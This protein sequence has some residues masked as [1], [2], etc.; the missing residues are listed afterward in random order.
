MHITILG[1]SPSWQDAG[2]ACTGYLVQEAQ[3]TVLLDCGNGVFAKLREAVDYS[4]VDH[5]VVSHLHAD[6]CLDLVPFAYALTY[7][8][9][10]G[11]RPQLFVPPGGISLMRRL[12]ELW[13]N[14]DLVDGAFRI[15]EYDPAASLALGDL[16]AR[17]TPVPHYIDTNAV[18]LT[19]PASGR[20][21]TFSADCGPNDALV[22]FARDTDLL[23]IEA[24][25][26]DPEPGEL[27]GH[28]TAT[29]AGEHARRA[30][31]RRVVLTHFSD[32]IDAGA[33]QAAGTAAFGAPVELARAG[34]V[35]E[36]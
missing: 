28:L 21:F 24:T 35:L 23:L 29:E 2:G 11:A 10:A 13:G 6:H 26:T 31:A 1:K 20:R 36:L 17:F 8:P 4:D 15:T 7:G 25:L 32:E 19:A 18:E 33:Q 5:V 3:T 22:E 12:S 9:R 30:G 16:A 27:R 34:V 14:A